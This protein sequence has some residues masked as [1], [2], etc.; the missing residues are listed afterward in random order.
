MN[1]RI[2]LYGLLFVATV[3]QVML[4]RRTAWFPDLILLIVVFA[5]IFHGYAEGI[6]LG[7]VAGILRGS[8][9]VYTLPLD[10]FLFPAAGALSAIL[11]ERV[12]RQNPVVEM[13]ITSFVMIATIAVHAL[14][15]K[16]TS[17]NQLVG[18]WSVLLGSSRAVIVTIAVSPVFFFLLRGLRSQEE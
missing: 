13:V 17:G 2:H 10:V 14:Y 4:M 15:L 3:C 5:G 18:I 12:Y 16:I 1:K 8:L 11:A 7:F 9:S 6:R